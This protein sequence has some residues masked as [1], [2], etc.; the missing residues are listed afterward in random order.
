[1]VVAQEP[2]KPAE[3]LNAGT[4]PAGLQAPP[5]AKASGTEMAALTRPPAA[6]LPAAPAAAPHV[7]AVE[8]DAGRLFVQGSGAPGA[9]LDIYLNGTHLADAIVGRDGRWSLTVKNGLAAGD[10]EVRVDQ[11]GPGGKVIARAA[12]PFDYHP[13]GA[14]PSPAAAAKLSTAAPTA[15]GE[16]GAAPATHAAAAQ[17]S[18][19]GTSVAPSGQ[20][21]AATALSEDRR[22]TGSSAAEPAGPTA[23]STAT[24]SAAAPAPSQATPSVAPPTAEQAAAHPVIES[25]GTVKIVRGDNLWRISRTIYGRGIRYTVIYAANQDQIR[26]PDLIFPGQ[27]FVIPPAPPEGKAAASPG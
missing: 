12:V 20:S 4:P 22:P 19:T 27:V 10:Y 3:I 16:P 1:M 23:P 17:P 13:A 24:V 25:I 9:R 14:A 21:P 8:T 15:T 5:P 11:L 2:G 26:D 18:A 6:T 7:D